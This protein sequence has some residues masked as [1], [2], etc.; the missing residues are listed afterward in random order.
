M[1]LFIAIDFEELKYY[2]SEVQEMLRK[3]RDAEFRYV[4]S[5]H[6]TLKFLGNVAPDKLEKVK[7]KLRDVRFSEFE[8][9]LDNIGSF[10]N[11]KSPRVVWINVKPEV[12]VIS[13]QKDIDEKLK[14]LFEK[15]SRFKPHIT[16]ARVKYIKDNEIK[17][18]FLKEIF[19]LNKKLK[20]N[21]FNLYKSTLAGE[22]VIHEI[23]EKYP[24][25]ISK[26]FAM[27]GN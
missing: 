14:E 27:T 24:R 5:Y 26:K 9:S 22:G 19:F 12:H 8:L 17:K 11:D 13:L 25:K 23:I 3:I 21:N 1:R 16:L 4:N 10:P 15:D 20:I 6:L 7:N 18:K 2:L